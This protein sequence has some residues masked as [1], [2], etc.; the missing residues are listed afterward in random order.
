MVYNPFNGSRRSNNNSRLNACTFLAIL[1]LA[2]FSVVYFFVPYTRLSGGFYYIKEDLFT[3]H[4]PLNDAC[5]TLGYTAP[6]NVKDKY[7]DL[8][9]RSHRHTFRFPHPMADR[10]LC[11]PAKNGNKNW[12]GLF[13][14]MWFGKV[15]NSKDIPNEA[16][17]EISYLGS[18]RAHNRHLRY[19]W[20]V[21]R[22]PYVRLLSAYLEKVYCRASCAG[23]D[24]I[25]GFSLFR[26]LGNVTFD[27]FVSVLY[28]HVLDGRSAEDVK[29]LARMRMLCE[30]DHHM[31]PQSACLFRDTKTPVRI[32][33]LEDQ[34]SWFKQFTDCFEIPQS[35]LQGEQWQAHNHQNCFYTP[36]G[37]CQDSLMVTSNSS[38]TVDGVHGK[39]AVNFLGN[40]YTPKSAEM[41]TYLYE[42][43]FRKL[44]HSRYD[45]TMASLV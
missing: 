37:D 34:G 8:L 45:G 3:Y 31:C 44:Q 33:K 28:H 17:V 20:M 9:Q 14:R 39:G 43:D 10:Y 26:P 42:Y 2:V 40:F 38:L 24:Y 36:T 11:V 7:R 5:K 41:V 21:T 23:H 6:L 35:V 19:A 13:Y 12:G 27:E 32:L 15:L 30:L 25:G 1:I 18:Q 22:S 16:M 4:E 29:P